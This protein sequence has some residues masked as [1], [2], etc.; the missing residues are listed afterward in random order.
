MELEVLKKLR[1]NE[2]P[3][4][5][6]KDSKSVETLSKEEQLLIKLCKKQG[7]DPITLSHLGAIDPRKENLW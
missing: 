7:V 5:S 2:N 6:E 4:L 1:K 3:P